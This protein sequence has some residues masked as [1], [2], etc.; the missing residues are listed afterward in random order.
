VAELITRSPISFGGLTAPNRFVHQPMECNDSPGG[1]PGELTFKRYKRLAEGKAGITV[2]EATSVGENRARTNQLMIDEEHRPGIKSLTK[3]F[4]E[5]NPDTPLFYQLNHAGQISGNFNQQG[6]PKSEVVRAY[7]PVGFDCNPGRLLSSEDIDEII[8]AFITGAV[9]AHDSGADGVDVKLCHGYLGGQLL[10]PA[11]N[12]DWEYGG[13]LENRMRFPERVITG[14]RERIPEFCIMVRISVYEGDK[15]ASG[16]PIAGGIGTTR[17]DSTEHSLEE[18]LEIL[19]M[20][21]SYG[22]DIVNIS[23]GIPVYNADKWVRPGRLPAGFDIDDP[24]TYAKYHHLANSLEAKKLDLG[25]PVIA[26]GFSIFGKNIAQVAENAI[27]HGFSDMVGIG[28]Q[29]LADPNVE[30]ILS[31]EADY[32]IKCRGCAKLLAG[33]VSVGCSN[34]NQDVKERLKSL[35]QNI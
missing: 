24:D 26:S 18:P 12:R 11:N 15:T 33:Q 2:V 16:E 27:K 25:I 30:R 31:G 14:I 20:L 32:C 21:K 19:R 23:A 7:E 34:Y 17:H 9:I 4:K 3:A 22:I 6:I 28:R 35:R 8:E 29:S 5:I 10:R 13:S 1:F